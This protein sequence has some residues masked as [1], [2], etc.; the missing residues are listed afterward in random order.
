MNNTKINAFEFEI[1]GQWAHFKR[2]ETNNNPLTHDFIT[3]PAL[4]GLIGAVIGIERE[5]M[6]L[7]FP[8]FSVGFKYNVILK[9]D[10]KKIAWS[11]T[12]SKLNDKNN[13]EYRPKYFEFLKDP[14]YIVTLYCEDNNLYEYF[15]KFKISILNYEEIYP[16]VLGWH[17]CK[18]KMNY[19]SEGFIIKKNGKFK[20][21]GFFKQTKIEN[22]NF[23]NIRFG[24]DKIPTY[25]NENFWNDPDKYIDIIYPIIKEKNIYVELNDYYYSYEA[26]SLNGNK[27][28][29][30]CCFV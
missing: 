16:A 21:Q 30:E 6:K 3:K 29:M 18:A 4:L 15:E 1:Y 24:F 13:V 22:I 26:T 17:N 25:Q 5:E 19:I 23:N 20:T 8:L 11:F 9:N 2:P 28:I 10:I 7:K 27:T 14:H 12:S